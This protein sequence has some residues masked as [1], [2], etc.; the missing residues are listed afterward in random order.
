MSYCHKPCTLRKSLFQLFF[1]NC[2]VRVAFNVLYRCACFFCNN[3]PWQLVAVV[4]HYS[5]KN[6]VTFFKKIHSVAVGN[7]IEAFGCIA[8]KY[9]FTLRPCINELSDC[10]TGLLITFCSFET[11]II[12]ST[13][14][15]CIA[16]F[17]ELHFRIYNRFRSLSSCGT[18]EIDYRIF[19]Q[20]R[21]IFLKVFHLH[22]L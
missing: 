14:R 18:V 15:I 7:K 21:K 5:D 2:A 12:K 3:S 20:K 13:Q 9:Y 22:S 19:S 6:F 10:F 1:G 4:F 17:V 16:F 11:Q 8:C